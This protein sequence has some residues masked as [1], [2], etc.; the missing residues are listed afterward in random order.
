MTLPVTIDQ[1]RKLYCGIPHVHLIRDLLERIQIHERG[2]DSWRCFIRIASTEELDHEVNR[3]TPEN[4]GSSATQPLAGIPVAIKDN[5]DTV[6]LGCSAGSVLLQDVPVE[7]DAPVVTALREAGAVLIGKTNLSEW[8][9]FR[10]THSTSGWSSA[11][12]QTRNPGAADRTPCGSSSGSA[13]AVAGGLVPVAVGTETDGSIICPAAMQGLVGFKPT[14]GR[15][16]QTGIVPIAWSQDTAGPIAHT[17]DDAWA[18]QSVLESARRFDGTQSVDSQTPSLEAPSALSSTPPLQPARLKDARI[19]VYPPGV[20]AHP[21]VVN[22]YRTALEHLR[23]AGAVLQEVVALPN[24]D[25]INRAEWVILRYEFRTGIE[26]YLQNR[27]PGS[28]WKTLK[29]LRRENLRRS[30]SV[31]ALFGQE[32]WDQSLDDSALTERSYRAALRYVDRCA[33]K[34]G[35]DRWF[36]ELGLDVVVA[37]ANGP[38]WVIDTVNGDRDTGSAT[39]P[40]PAAGYPILTVPMDQVRSLPIGIAF[41]GPANADEKVFRFGKAWERLVK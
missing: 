41:Y 7:E 11:G 6:T 30:D 39:P 16:P 12:G 36:T 1:Y 33:R 34:N 27:R 22:V 13:S 8:A 32:I 19:G 15:V 5:I 23:R 26:R 17:V 21:D 14:V 3:R 25:R 38:A 10:S 18:V 28:P 29:E 35:M 20:D 4:G 40:A 24:S 31:L 2:P 37:P 9:N